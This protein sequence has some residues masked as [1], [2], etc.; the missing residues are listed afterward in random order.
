MIAVDVKTVI[1]SGVTQGHG[2]GRGTSA[3]GRTP[4]VSPRRPSLMSTIARVALLSSANTTEA[5]RRYA[6]LT[7]DVRLA[8]VQSA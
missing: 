6:D 7:I 1:G 5:A 3:R 2:L 4:R 8:R